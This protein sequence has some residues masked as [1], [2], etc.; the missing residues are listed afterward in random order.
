ML[1]N[2]ILLLKSPPHFL[3]PLPQTHL[4]AFFA[5]FN[6]LSMSVTY[7][8][9]SRGLAKQAALSHSLCHLHFVFCSC[10]YLSPQSSVRA[11]R[12]FLFVSLIHL[13]IFSKREVYYFALIHW[14]F[15]ALILVFDSLM[16]EKTEYDN[17]NSN[18]ISIATCIPFSWSKSN[19]F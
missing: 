2:V 14:L 5:L 15:C 11:I 16:P 3:S 12:L 17:F 6:S 1:S 4:T 8:V 18:S 13:N 7:I 9:N 10:V 19:N